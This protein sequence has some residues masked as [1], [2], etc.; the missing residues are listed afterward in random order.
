MAHVVLNIPDKQLKALRARAK[1]R[2][3]TLRKY[4]LQI[5]SGEIHPDWPAGYFERVFGS[6]SGKLDRARQGELEVREP[7]D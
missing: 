2:K 7:L 1:A 6:W 5:V 4:L 3:L